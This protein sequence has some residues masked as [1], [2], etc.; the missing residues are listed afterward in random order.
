MLLDASHRRWIIACLAG[1][2][3]ATAAYVPYARSALHGPRGG[4]W[5]GLGYGTAGLAL[6]LYAGVLGLRRRVPMWRV[7]RATTWMKGHLWLGLLSYPLILFHSGFQL[8]GPLTLV[9]M[10][11]FT[12]VIVSGVYG[13]VL[14]QY[15]PRLMLARLPLE[16][17]YE[18]ID[19]VVI[20]LRGDADSLI[21][22]AAGAFLVEEAPAALERRGG[23][24]IRR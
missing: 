5:I 8:G 2:A 13:V 24:G 11:L 15:L 20:Q 17:V 12:V 6:M 7:G 18:Q 14:Q 3:L 22:S 23:D 4:S 21:E 9:L 16:T 1:L 10:V 19:E